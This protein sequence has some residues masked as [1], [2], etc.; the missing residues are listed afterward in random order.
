RCHSCRLPQSRSAGA[1]RPA[2]SGAGRPGSER[3]PVTATA[4]AVALGLSVRL[5]GRRV[6]LIGVGP[7]IKAALLDGESITLVAILIDHFWWLP[8]RRI[9][10]HVVTV[11]GRLRQ[12]LARRLDHDVILSVL[13]IGV[14]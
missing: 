7:G 3:Y 5:H 10:F 4:Q 9:R 6:W 12:R 2:G 1:R 14:V 8:I 11:A 13:L